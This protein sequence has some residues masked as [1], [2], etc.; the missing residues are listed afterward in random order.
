MFGGNLK[1]GLFAA[2][3]FPLILIVGLAVQLKGKRKEKTA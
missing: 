2:T 3:V 1:V